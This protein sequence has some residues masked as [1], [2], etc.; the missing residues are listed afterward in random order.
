[1]LPKIIKRHRNGDLCTRCCE[2]HVFE[3]EGM[4][5]CDYCGLIYWQ[6]AD[7]IPFCQL[8]NGEQFV[9]V[10]DENGIVWTKGVPLEH[11]DDPEWRYWNRY[12]YWPNGRY[13]AG[14]CG[15]LA[16]VRRVT[17]RKIG[18]FFSYN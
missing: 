17:D 2:G 3:R 18:D 14:G 10:G 11:S 1:M 4:Q 8:R 9:S 7:T 12:A 16:T 6:S 15:P 5:L 13:R